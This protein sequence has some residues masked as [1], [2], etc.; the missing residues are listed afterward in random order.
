MSPQR[1]IAMRNACAFFESPPDPTNSEYVVLEEERIK[2]VL[3]PSHQPG[4]RDSLIP[5]DSLWRDTTHLRDRI[6]LGLLMGRTALVLGRAHWIPLADGRGLR[7]QFV[8]LTS[9]YGPQAEPVVLYESFHAALQEERRIDPEKTAE[10]TSLWLGITL[11]ELTFQQKLEDQPFFPDHLQNGQPNDYTFQ[12][13]AMQW[14]KYAELDHD[15]ELAEAIMFCLTPSRMSRM[16]PGTAPCISE[17]LE[18]V[19]QPLEGVLN[20]MRAPVY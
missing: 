12:T 6:K 15:I 1:P 4:G 19:L 14:Q 13:A 20:S 5:C 10:S 9:K 16:N 17:V 18:H 3:R 11:L 7:N 2:L 8:C